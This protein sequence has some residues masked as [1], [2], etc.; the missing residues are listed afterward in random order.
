MRYTTVLRAVL[1]VS[2]SAVS[3]FQVTS[4]SV[5]EQGGGEKR[6]GTHRGA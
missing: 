5:D 3:A 6:E 2:E 1:D 4:S